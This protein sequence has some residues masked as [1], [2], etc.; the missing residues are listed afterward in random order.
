[1]PL[2]LGKYLIALLLFTTIFGAGFLVIADFNQQYPSTDVNVDLSNA[3]QDVFN[4]YLEEYENLSK[5]LKDRSLNES[6]ETSSAIDNLVNG[7]YKAIR[8]IGLSFKGIP[9]MFGII[10]DKLH[11]NPMFV[12][13]VTSAA[14]I[15]V[16]IAL[17]YLFMRII[18]G[19]G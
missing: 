14:F 8:L 3:E 16:A 9:M 15:L 18:P 17:I 2:E 6:T 1:M 7:A 5:E 11:I 10:A 4:N 12:F 13:V 19:G